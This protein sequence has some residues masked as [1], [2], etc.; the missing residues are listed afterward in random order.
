MNRPLF[1]EYISGSNQIEYHENANRYYRDLE[2]Y[3][4]YLENEI[5]NNKL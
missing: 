1:I 3:C 5:N 2:R 4:D